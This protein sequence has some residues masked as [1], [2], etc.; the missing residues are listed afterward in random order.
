MLDVEES[1]FSRKREPAT[2]KVLN[3]QFF[4][5]NSSFFIQFGVNYATESFQSS[6][7][8]CGFRDGWAVVRDSHRSCFFSLVS[9]GFLEP[10]TRALV[11]QDQTT[12]SSH[13]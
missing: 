9:I 7:F 13:Q 2:K 4:I 10:G 11:S 8:E 6:Y 3:S 1:I 12:Q 5:L